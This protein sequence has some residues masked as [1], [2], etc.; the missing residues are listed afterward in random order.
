MESRIG[1]TDH[2]HTFLARARRYR[3]QLQR[4]Y[5]AFELHDGELLAGGIAFF[6][7]LSLAPMLVVALALASRVLGGRALDGVLVAELKPLIGETAATFVSDVLARSEATGFSGHAAVFGTLVTIYA[8]GR[9][10]VQV[11][12]ALNRIWHPT[13]R[14]SGSLRQR[15]WRVVEKRVLSFALVLGLGLLLAITTVAKASL[16]WLANQLGLP[17]VPFLWHAADLGLSF[18][19]L[20]CT[21]AAVYRF[22]PDSSIG[23]R[24]ALRGGLITAIFLVLGTVAVGVYLDSGVVSSAFGA[25][26]SLVVFMLSAYYGAIIFL[27]GAELTAV[28]AREEGVLANDERTSNVF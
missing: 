1:A 17:D 6:A 21:L 2:G 14:E 22:L 26:G 28:Y 13:P 7:V 5:L 10:F 19:A 16:S 12:I 11:Q 18:C 8:S 15:A 23:F 3:G 20:V 27:Y 24:F 9:L 25:A 4:A